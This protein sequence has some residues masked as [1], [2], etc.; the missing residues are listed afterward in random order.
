MIK[1]IFSSRSLLCIGAG[2]AAFLVGLRLDQRAQNVPKQ[3]PHA[4]VRPEIF[5]GAG[6]EEEVRERIEKMS[7]VSG[8]LFFSPEEWMP[9]EPVLLEGVDVSHLFAGEFVLRKSLR[10]DFLFKKVVL[11]A[12]FSRPEAFVDVRI[13][14]RADT[15][16]V[17]R[18][19]KDGMKAMRRTEHGDLGEVVTAKIQQPPAGCS[20][21]EVIAKGET[22]RVVCGGITALQ[23]DG[24]PPSAGKVLA[25]SN[26][27]RDEVRELSI[28]G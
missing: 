23:V 4:M 22:Y 28:D 9:I 10:E 8:P 5:Q 20:R 6:H 1:H 7:G 25:A 21:Y 19:S 16:L 3:E 27:R 2:F 15:W 26:L 13:P 14:V 17:L 18:F 12:T 11:D 24:A